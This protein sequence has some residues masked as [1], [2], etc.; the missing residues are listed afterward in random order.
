MTTCTAT[1][2]TRPAREDH[3]HLITLQHADYCP[4]TATQTVG[5]NGSSTVKSATI[6]VYPDV[7]NT[8]TYTAA[9]GYRIA[10]F[11]N[12]SVEVAAAI[13][14]TSYALEN[15]AT[16]DAI[17]VTFEQIPATFIYICGNHGASDYTGEPQVVSYVPIQQDAIT[18]TA[19]D[20]YVIAQVATNGVGIAILGQASFELPGFTVPRRDPAG[21]RLL[22]QGECLVARS[23][24]AERF[25]AHWGCLQLILDRQD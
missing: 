25:P 13:G 3:P 7:N 23:V 22:R 4:T 14:A 8:V 21:H 9:A 10:A 5:A 24:R 2:A 12:N 16:G 1:S 6:Y 11:T 19:A 17:V 18:F 15:I 20:G